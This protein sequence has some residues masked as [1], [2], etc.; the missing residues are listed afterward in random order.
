GGQATYPARRVHLPVS[1]GA[2]P[3]KKPV[4][5]SRR[6][7]SPRAQRASSPAQSDMIRRTAN[8]AESQRPRQGGW[9]MDAALRDE[10][11]AMAGEDQRVRA[12]LA[13]DGSLF[14]G[15]HPRMEEVHRR[16]AARLTAIIE[17]HASP[18]PPLV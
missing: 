4:Q 6:A 10:L 15:Y 14:D 13:A 18:R 5:L 1:W 8:E 16:N 12:E 2:N 17:G 9:A 7:S 3:Q 11:L